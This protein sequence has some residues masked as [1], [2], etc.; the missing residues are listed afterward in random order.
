MTLTKD[1]L[2]L[3]RNGFV[4]FDPA[5]RRAYGQQLALLKLMAGCN[6]GGQSSCN[7]GLN[8]MVEAPQQS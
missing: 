1:A 7:V 2:E 3:L 4:G 5:L 8:N 6:A